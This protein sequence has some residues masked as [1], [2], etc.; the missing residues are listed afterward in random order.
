MPV[1]SAMAKKAVSVVGIAVPTQDTT[2][3]WRHNNIGRLLHDAVMRFETTILGLLAECGYGDVRLAHVNVT[4]NLDLEGTRGI[5]LAARAGMTKQAM[6][7]LIEQCVGLGLVTRA[8]DPADG[9]AKIIRFTK[10]GMKFLDHFREAVA[11]A[12]A[13]MR[14]E[15]GENKLQTLLDALWDYSH[16]RE[17]SL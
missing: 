16:P 10:K 12:Q 8:Q 6:G 11:T 14:D 2:G 15:L 5:D 3:N 13:E 4:R 7:E 17:G 1:R 9:R